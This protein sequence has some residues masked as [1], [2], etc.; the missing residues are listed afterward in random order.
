MS[1]VNR[2]FWGEVLAVV[3][4]IDAVRYGIIVAMSAVSAKRKRSTHGSWP[5]LSNA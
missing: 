5:T 4:L 1:G 3:A 2:L